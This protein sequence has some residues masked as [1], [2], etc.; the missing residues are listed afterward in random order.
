L[1][2]GWLF[3][4]DMGMRNPRNV[5]ILV[6][7]DIEILDFAGPYE[8]F[9]VASDATTPASFYVYNV[10]ISMRPI[11]GRGRFTVSPQYS[12]ENCPQA[13]L[14]VIPGGYGTRPLMKHEVLMSWLRDQ[15][16]KVEWL[17]SVC[18]GALLLARAGLLENCSATTHHTAYAEL[19]EASPRTT[20][21][22]GQRF[23]QASP[24]IMTA[25]GISAGIDL[26]LHMVEL[27][28]GSQARAA[29]EEEMEYKGHGGR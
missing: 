5:A 6:F 7:D 18:T 9:N 20:V 16:K 13:D 4:Q 10:G 15:S 1:T 11:I 8:V 21:V 2:T 17:L 28:A 3:Q 12:I 26:S 23:V 29:A 25:G 19:K 22:E 27:L 14:L 24:A